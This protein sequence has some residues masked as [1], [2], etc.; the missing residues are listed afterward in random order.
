MVAKK[1]YAGS[2][3]NVGSQVVKAPLAT[4]AKKGNGNVKKGEDLRS[5]K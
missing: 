5:G 3:K 2:I 1:T 4:D